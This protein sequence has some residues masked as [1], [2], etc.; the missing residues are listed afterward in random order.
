[1]YV[2]VY[3]YLVYLNDFIIF[4]Y[5]CVNF[6][7]ELEV[8]FFLLFYFRGLVVLFSVRFVKRRKCWV[9][10]WNVVLVLSFLICGI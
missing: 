1:M 3:S 5:L 9:G 10:V 7:V 8:L 6:N 2:G 4:S